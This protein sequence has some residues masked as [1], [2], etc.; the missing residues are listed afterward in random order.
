[1]SSLDVRYA[2]LLALEPVGQSRSVADVVAGVNARGIR[3]GN[4]PSKQVSDLLRTECSRGRVERVGW[5]TYRLVKFSR[6]TR[7]R[8][9]VSVEATVAW[10]QANEPTVDP[11]V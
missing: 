1:M 2:I 6:R 8:A 7:G 9:L 3:L 5:G 4:R 11:D 10:L